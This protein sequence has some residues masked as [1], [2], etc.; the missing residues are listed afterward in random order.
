MFNGEKIV[1]ISVFLP[2]KKGQVE[3]R[4]EVIENNICSKIRARTDPPRER[5]NVKR[6]FA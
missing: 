4:W 2:L 3:S 5:P 1:S 6:W